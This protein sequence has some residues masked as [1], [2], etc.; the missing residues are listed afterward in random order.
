M[1]GQK[2]VSVTGLHGS[3]DIALGWVIIC[4]EVVSLLDTQEQQGLIYHPS[5]F[6]RP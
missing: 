3:D 1:L 4:W 5:S 6:K 2:E